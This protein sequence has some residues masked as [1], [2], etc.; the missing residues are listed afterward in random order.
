[1]QTAFGAILFFGI[2]FGM[3]GHLGVAASVAAGIAFF[4]LQIFVSQ[5]YMARFSI[6]PVE[7]L[8]RSLTYL[9]WQPISRPAASAA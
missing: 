3:L 7:W 2:G 5:W 9:K 1:V 6:G 8:W 4:V